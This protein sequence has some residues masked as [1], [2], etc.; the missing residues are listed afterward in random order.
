MGAVNCAIGSTAPA[1]YSSPSSS[2]GFKPKTWLKT[3]NFQALSQFSLST[4]VLITNYKI[5]SSHPIWFVRNLYLYVKSHRPK[6]LDK[7]SLPPNVTKAVADPARNR[8]F[9]GV[10]RTNLKSPK[11]TWKSQ[12]KLHDQ[13][14]LIPTYLKWLQ[15]FTYSTQYQKLEREGII[16]QKASGCFFK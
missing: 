14:K 3:E 16:T 4:A 15:S 2:A 12:S 8:I 10:I 7:V 11:S 6:D 5:P 1:R 13:F 9:F